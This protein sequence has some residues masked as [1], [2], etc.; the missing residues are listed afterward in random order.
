M[1]L[2]AVKNF[3]ISHG[4]KLVVAVVAA[5]S[6]WM[7][8]NGLQQPNILDKHQPEALATN[9]NTVRQQI[10]EE[11]R[12]EAIIPERMPQFDIVQET[13]SKRRPVDA[14]P[15]R[16]AHLLERKPIDMS[17]RRQD[18]ALA[19]PKALR[20]SGQIESIA[21]LSR[22][23]QYK[24]KD[25]GPAEAIKAEEESGPRKSKSSSSNSA[26]RKQLEEDGVPQEA[27]EAMLAEAEEEAEREESYSPMGMAATGRSFK[28]EYDFGARPAPKNNAS[29]VPAV[30]W[31][32][33]GTAVVPHRMLSESFQAALANANGYLPER[34]QPYYFNYQIQRADV[35]AKRV[36]QLV[37]ADWTTIRDREKDL[38]RAA[39]QW[40]GFAPELVPEE[41]RDPALT[42]YI[43]PI[44]LRDYASFSLHPLVPLTPPETETVV[45]VD[46]AA[47]D[48]DGENLRLLDPIGGG[49][50]NGRDDMR[51]AMGM[52]AASRMTQVE[53]DPVEHKLMRFFDFW[54][55]DPQSVKPGRKYVYR[56]R[57]SIID[58]NFPPNPLQQPKV[59]TLAGPVYARVQQLM[60]KAATEG[61]RDFQRWSGW[62]EPSEP[63]SLPPV[64][65]YFAGPVNSPRS[66]TVQHQG[67][68]V[69]YSRDEPTARIVNFR[70]NGELATWMP[71]WIKDIKPGSVLSHEGNAEAIDPIALTVKKVPDAKVLSQ[72]TVV[73]LDGG[74][75]LEIVDS[76][77][78]MTEPGLMLLVDERGNL[79]VTSEVGDQEQYRIYSFADERGR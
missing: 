17:I 16:L 27:I 55:N 74:E 19:A 3:F 50:S 26:M 10:E 33:A 57:Y 62:S 13:L 34:D 23:G 39:L 64:H 59:S 71:V 35:S 52:A 67:K 12:T 8:Y 29:P 2:D 30:G 72:A 24:L 15:Y 77:E 58:P 6:I 32:I 49:M 18:P 78:E 40:A 68:A 5:A 45:E 65:D 22:S 38:K 42:T 20:V 43:P 73:D 79:K 48:Q 9:A 60:Q 1:D 75:P 63:V 37:D 25:L 69:K 28:S 41:Y 4:E 66:R 51:V 70:F 47:E 7:I 46:P 31:F 11:D 61:R 53:M 44:L 36:D 14:D 21:M 54:S 76:E 56:V